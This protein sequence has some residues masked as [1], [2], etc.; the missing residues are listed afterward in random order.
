M[1]LYS[2]TGKKV[3]VSFDYDHDRHY[4]YLLKG[5]DANKSLFLHPVCIRKQK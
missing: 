5:W 3:F 2:S 1:Y 4:Y